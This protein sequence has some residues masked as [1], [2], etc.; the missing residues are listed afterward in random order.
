LTLVYRIKGTHKTGV[1]GRPLVLSE[2]EEEALVQVL[3]QMGEFNYPLTRRHLMDMVKD[4]LVKKRDTRFKDNRPGRMWVPKFLERH[5]DR[6]TIKKPSNIRRSRAAVSPDD[7]RE[8][9]ANLTRELEG[10]SPSN[11]F[12]CDESCLQ[13]DP[14]AH[15]CIFPK[16]VRYPEQARGLLNL[17]STVLYPTVPYRTGISTAV[18]HVE[19]K[20]IK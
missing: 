4:Y 6:V 5:K 2:A 12:N 20:F 19:V 14:S 15:K 17:T 9:H 3:I 18:W 10:I 13:D 7:I 1:V 8:Y 16:G 11:I